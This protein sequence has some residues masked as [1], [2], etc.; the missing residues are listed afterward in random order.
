MSAS[1]PGKIVCVGLNYRAHAREQ[2]VDPPTRPLLFAKWPNTVVLDGGPIVVPSVSTQIDYEGE[3]GVV[4]G[5]VARRVPVSTALDFVDSYVAANDVTARDIQFGDGQWT[6]GK[7]LD[8]FLPISDRRPAR[9]VPDPQALHLRTL[10]NGEVMQDSDTSDMIFDVPSIIA[11]VTE[12]ITLE[13]GDLVLT[14]TPA[15]V[16]AHRDP[17]VWLRPGDV[18]T[19]EIEGVGSVTSPVVSDEPS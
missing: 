14:G 17:P 5:A 18:V 4:I 9:E 19:V 3:L 2:G 15:G 6:R 7:S 8:T 10:V 16:G 1:R 11:F 12:A 13:P